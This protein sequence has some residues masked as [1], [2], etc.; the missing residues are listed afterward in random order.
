MALSPH[1][2]Q[3]QPAIHNSISRLDTSKEKNTFWTLPCDGCDKGVFD[4]FSRCNE[5]V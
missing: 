1:Q 4:Y 3:L 2:I 5:T